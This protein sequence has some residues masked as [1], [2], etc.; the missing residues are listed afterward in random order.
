MV[1]SKST[2][3]FSRLSKRNCVKFACLESAALAAKRILKDAHRC[4]LL[5]FRQSEWRFRNVV[6]TNRA[7]DATHVYANDNYFCCKKCM[8]TGVSLIEYCQNGNH[9][10]KSH[11]CIS[12]KDVSPLDSAWKKAAKC[13]DCHSFTESRA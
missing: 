5:L 12:R 8:L 4:L 10:S 6:I 3:L 9:H 1:S 11:S 13:H 7:I 2:C